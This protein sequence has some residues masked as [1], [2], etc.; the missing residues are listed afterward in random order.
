MFTGR[1]ARNG[2]IS[3]S[4]CQFW[5]MC[6]KRFKYLY[7]KPFV[8]IMQALMPSFFTWFIMAMV[9]LKLYQSHPPLHLSLSLFGETIVVYGVAHS[10]TTKA[11][12]LGEMYRQ[13]FDGGSQE[14]VCLNNLS[15]YTASDSVHEYLLQKGKHDRHDYS[16]QLFVAAEFHSGPTGDVSVVAFYN[17]EAFHTTAISLNLVDNALLKHYVGSD[18]SIETTNYPRQVEGL[19]SEAGKISVFT[20]GILIAMGVVIALPVAIAS[21]TLY[22][23]SE[24][25]IGAK[26]AHFISGLHVPIYWTAMFVCDNIVYVASACLIVCMFFVY[27]IKA[28]I[29]AECFPA[30]VLLFLLYGWASLPMMYVASFIFNSPG[31]AL[32][33]TTIFNLVSGE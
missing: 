2:C 23:V 9:E 6:M 25:V 12:A 7:R 15:G 31:N 21:F 20:K 22:A 30:T 4:L 11:L 5:A 33:W 26:N 18:Y 8:P 17:Y 16:Y 13:Q 29:G 24:R 19:P 10:P 3:L 27:D 1:D 28:F 14:V 32:A